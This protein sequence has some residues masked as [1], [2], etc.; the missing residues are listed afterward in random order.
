MS[1]AS[2]ILRG[3][4]LGALGGCFVPS[5]VDPQTDGPWRLLC[6]LGL[7]SSIYGL[8]IVLGP[9]LIIR[10][11]GIRL[12]THWPVRRDIPW[13]RIYD[14]EVVPGYWMIDI[15]LNSGEAV[16]LP[17]VENVDLLFDDIQRGRERLDA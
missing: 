15:E 17:C 9:A 1:R 13:Y 4:L 14:I 7:V 2:R 10:E 8:R 12:L 3:G 16:S 6:L 11:E 5:L